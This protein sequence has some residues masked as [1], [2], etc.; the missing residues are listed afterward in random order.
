VFFRKITKL[1]ATV[2]LLRPLS[3]FLSDNIGLAATSELGQ[4]GNVGSDVHDSLQHFPGLAQHIF[5]LVRIDI[6]PDSGSRAARTAQT[7]DNPAVIGEND[8]QTLKYARKKLSIGTLNLSP[9]TNHLLGGHRLVDWVVVAEIIGQLHRVRFS[10]VTECLSHETWFG[11]LLFQR[12]HHGVALVQ[13]TAFVVVTREIV[14]TISLPVL[15]QNVF[16]ALLGEFHD[17]EPGQ[18]GPD[19]V[20]FANVVGTSAERSFD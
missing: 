1:H 9:V 10:I 2:T 19:A 8:S 16:D 6:Q 18:N 7:N 14:A 5:A 17:R 13:I 20:L 12:R 4:T 11:H 15:D 3:H